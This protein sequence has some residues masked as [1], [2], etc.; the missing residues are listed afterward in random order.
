[1]LTGGP[2]YNTT[3]LGKRYRPKSVM[4]FSDLYFA[5]GENIILSW[6]HKFKFPEFSFTVT[7]N[8]RDSAIPTGT[9][10]NVSRKLRD[11]FLG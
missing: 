9:F 10:V 8:S 1:M 4:L 2:S 7:P 5:T 6:V 11:M 3:C